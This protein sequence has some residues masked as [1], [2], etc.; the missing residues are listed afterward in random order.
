MIDEH[1]L[2]YCAGIIDADGTIGIKKNTYSMRI[3]GDSTQPS[4]SERICVKQVEA[5]AIDLLH[6][7]FGGYRFTS[8]PSTKNGKLLHG[9]QVTDLKATKTLTMVLPHLRIK[10]AQAIN[11]LNL[12]VLKDISKEKRVAKGRGH[13][14]A[15]PRSKKIS[16][17]ME[18][19]YKF[20][21]ELNGNKGGD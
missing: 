12:R 15:A 16:D 7:I 1:I 11:C 17:K 3:I 10:K 13:V 20:A 4:Y 14:G 21:H 18:E 2:A 19:H 9:W 8:K 5:E 6:K